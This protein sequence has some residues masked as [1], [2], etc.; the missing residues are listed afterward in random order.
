MINQEWTI[1]RNWQHW[2]HMT[3]DEDKQNKNHNTENYKD[4]QHGPTRFVFDVIVE[5]LQLLEARSSY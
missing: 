5:H 4:E 3:Q 2:V 1:L